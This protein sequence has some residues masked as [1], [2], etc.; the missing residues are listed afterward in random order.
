MPSTPKS[1]AGPKTRDTGSV[2]PGQYRYVGDHAQILED[3]QPIGHGEYVT[4]QPEQVVG[5]NQM[6]V[7]DGH[8]IDASDITPPETE[9]PA[10]SEPA[11]P[12]P[13]IKE[14]TE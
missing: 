13:D 14:K 5:I 1:E 12:A 4:L 3:G 11:P 9:P 2:S 6:L 7:D 10:G 8:L